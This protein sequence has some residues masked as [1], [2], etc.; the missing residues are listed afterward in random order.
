[1]GALSWPVAIVALSGGIAGLF[2]ILMLRLHQQPQLN[3]LMS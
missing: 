3:P 1:M 2:S